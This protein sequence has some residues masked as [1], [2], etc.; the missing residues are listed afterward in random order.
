MKKLAAILFA[1]CLLMAG[2]MAL[3]EEGDAVWLYDDLSNSVY[4]EG[5]LQG[6][7]T[8]PASINEYASYAL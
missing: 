6:D 7:V 3:A 8:I 5:E 4:V 1:F 2:C